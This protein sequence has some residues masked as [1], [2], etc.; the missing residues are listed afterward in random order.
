[1]TVFKPYLRCLS[2]D[3]EEEEKVDT[4]EDDE[5]DKLESEASKKYLFKKLH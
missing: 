3:P 4:S 5:G 1:M 2:A